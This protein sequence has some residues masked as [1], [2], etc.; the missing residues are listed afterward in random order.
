MPALVRR[1]DHHYTNNGTAPFSYSFDGGTPQASNIFTNVTAGPHTV[2]FVDVF[3]CTGTVVMTVA[4]G[5][6]PLTATVNTTPTLSDSS[7]RNHYRYTH[8]RITG[9]S[10]SPRRR[11]AAA[12]EC[13]YQRGGGGRIL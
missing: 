10:L 7:R 1:N 8:Q 9:L 6:T 3:G 5:S 2:N 13:I 4:A 11:P 12:I